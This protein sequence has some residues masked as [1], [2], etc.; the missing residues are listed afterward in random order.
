MSVESA[1]TH[2]ASV[3]RRASQVRRSVPWLT[4][5]PFAVAMAYADG[6]WML[7]M[8]GAVGAIE[9][10]PEPPISVAGLA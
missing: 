5:V 4:V 9:R 1:S 8:R 6:F 2:S 3:D 10:T 7:A